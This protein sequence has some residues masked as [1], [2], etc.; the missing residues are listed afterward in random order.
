MNA[1]GNQPKGKKM[2]KY[3][4]DLKYQARTMSGGFVAIPDQVAM[5]QKGF[6]GETFP[7]LRKDGVKARAR[8]MGDE[9]GLNTTGTGDPVVR[10]V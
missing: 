3:S 6:D 4:F 7:V 8:L 1:T 10:M 5:D 2:T 9:Y